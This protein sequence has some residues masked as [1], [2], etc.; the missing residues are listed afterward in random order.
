MSSLSSEFQRE[1][2]AELRIKESR[3]VY[4][5]PLPESSKNWL[6]SGTDL[7]KV[8]GIKEDY[9]KDLNETIVK[10]IPKDFEIKRRKIDR[11]TRDFK[12]DSDGNYIYDD[13]KIKGGFLPVISEKNISL[14]YLYQPK[15]KGYDYI[16]FIKKKGE[17]EYVY[18]LE[19]EHLYKVNQTALAIS[20]KN[21][22]NFKGMGYKT[23]RNGTIFIHVI[24]Y[25]PRGSY[26]GS[27]ILETGIGIN[28]FDGHIK[29][30][31]DY[32]QKK[33]YLPTIDLCTVD[34]VNLVQK[35]TQVGYDDYIEVEDMS[36]N[37]KEIYG[38]MKDSYDE[39][40]YVGNSSGGIAFVD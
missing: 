21:M 8:S 38:S 28:A 18:S 27:K 25:N 10:K 29:E 19:K 24:P 7:Y 2:K 35:E 37:E 33:N 17:T 30:L 14:P 11:V 23:W 1:L 15:I 34:F 36:L 26:I 3:D 32:W 40:E 16:D 39:P 22:K 13:V 4:K 6:I 31:V 5:A 9:Y 20:I 12:K